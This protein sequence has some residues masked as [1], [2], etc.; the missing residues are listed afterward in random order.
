MSSSVEIA[1]KILANAAARDKINRFIQYYS[2]FLIW[3]G[4]NNGFSTE[5]ITKIQSVMSMFSTT[6]KVMRLGK[7]IE[8]FKNARQALSI[9]DD[10]T[11]MLTAYKFFGLGMWLMYDVLG[12]AHSYK[13]HLQKDIKLINKRT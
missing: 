3:F 11:R 2:K 9:K 4:Q 13:L 7:Q 12:L 10:I 6:R 8:Y 5:A 1:S